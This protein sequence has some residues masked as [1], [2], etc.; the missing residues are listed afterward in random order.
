MNSEI[1]LTLREI[2]DSQN[3]EAFIYN[4]KSNQI[5]L[6]NKKACLSLGYNIDEI[7]NS[8]LDII[9]S[10]NFKPII[11]SIAKNYT[12]KEL[13]QFVTKCGYSFIARTKKK[14]ISIKNKKYQFISFQKLSDLSEISGSDK[15]TDKEYI[16]F[17]KKLLTINQNI[18]NV[19][20]D[21]FYK[22][23]VYSLADAFK[24]RWAMICLLSPSK[25]EAK[26][27]SLWDRTKFN[28]EITYKLKGTPCAEVK[29]T[30]GHFYCE[31]NLTK[32]FPK[33]FMA[34]QWGV[35]SYLGIPITSKTDETLGF[36]SIMDDKP[37]KKEKLTSYIATMKFFS[38]RT[39]KEITISNFNVTTLNE[40]I[41]NKLSWLTSKN[42]PLT[43]REL[44]VL[45]H[46]CEGLT[47]DSIAKQLAV[48]L[49]TIK[50]HLKNIYNKLGV[51]GRNGLLKTV[52]NMR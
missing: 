23:M 24:V 8:H 15:N 22:N 11:L 26:I 40:E 3:E 6:A 17:S 29:K 35:E 27:I 42:T 19:F 21:M 7:I 33:D 32:H 14:I 31:K 5:L 18:T 52:S 13:R 2:I 28:S 38:S 30:K 43:K 44:Q 1:F 36:L 20:D 12:S 10:K 47:S 49:P 48:S 4:V 45:E 50:F 46:V 9:I 16:E 39:A 41:S 34:Y 51:N 37:I 25:K